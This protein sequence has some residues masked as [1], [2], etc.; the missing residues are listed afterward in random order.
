MQRRTF[1]ISTLSV[2][3]AT[4]GLTA[5]STGN[6]EYIKLSVK[7]PTKAKD[8]KVEVVEFFNYG[9]IHCYDFED[10]FQTW[11]N[12]KNPKLEIQQVHVAFDRASAIWQLTYY[13][14]EE[15]GI[16]EKVHR[17]LFDAIHKDKFT[18]GH[19]DDVAAWMEKQGIDKA[20]FQKHFQS[21]TTVENAKYANT[22]T[23]A[24]AISGTPSFGVNGEFYVEYRGAK[25]LTTIDKLTESAK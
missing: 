18:P 2:M 25:T 4:A 5:C 14:I 19:P 6:D 1:T 3:L 15:M 16:K 23:Q 17:K 10:D 24:Y 22:L 13:A 9:C 8:G 20:E 12:K 7:A 21:K 11:V